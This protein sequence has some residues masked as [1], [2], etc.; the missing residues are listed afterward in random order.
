MSKMKCRQIGPEFKWI[1]LVHVLW[2]NTMVIVGQNSSQQKN[3]HFL[4]NHRTALQSCLPSCPV[5]G[6]KM[7]N[8]RV[9]TY[10]LDLNFLFNFPLHLAAENSHL[11]VYY[12]PSILEK[13]DFLSQKVILL[14]SYLQIAKFL[15]EANTL[16]ENPHKIQALRIKYQIHILF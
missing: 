15:A 7:T 10:F 1:H 8:L 11:W 12:L 6:K 5:F 16:A 14:Q 9:L 13:L 3:S 2:I 4:T